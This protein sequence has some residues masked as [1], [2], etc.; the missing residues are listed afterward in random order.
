MAAL[1]ATAKDY[2]DQLSVTVNGSPLGQPEESTIKVNRND[3]G[4]YQLSLEDF[5]LMFGALKVGTIVVDNVAAV[6]KNGA[7]VLASSQSINIEEGSFGSDAKGP[8]LGIVPVNVK[9]EIRDDKLFSLIDINMPSPLNMFI[10]V[11]F[12][13]ST[14]YQIPNSGFEEFHTATYVDG[15][16]SYSS[17][18]PNAWHSFNSGVATG[19]LSM[20]TKLAL[21]NGS[22]YISTD[23]RPESTGTKSVTLVSGNVMKV[24][25]NGTMTTGR[26]QAGSIT[27][28]DPANCAFMDM[29]LTDVDGNGDPFYTVLNGMPDSLTVWVKY[30]Q[31]QENADYPYATVSAVITDGTYYQDPE[32][33]DVTYNNVV[34][35]AQDKEIESKD[36]TWQ[37]VSIPFDYATYAS[38]NA[39]GKALLVTISTNAQ[40]GVGSRDANNPDVLYVDDIALVYNYKLASLSV[41]GSEISGFDED[42]LEYTVD[43]VIT[44]DDIEAVANGKGASVFVTD[45]TEFTVT[46]VA[47]D[48]LNS[49]T[50]TIHAPE[51]TIAKTIPATGLASFSAK[52]NVTVPEGVTVCTAKINDDET[53]VLLN[54]V[55]ANVIPANTG[56]LIWH[57]DGGDFTFSAT[58]TSADESLFAENDLIPTSID[59]KA[60]VPASGVFYALNNAVLEF[61]VLQNGI[62]LGGHLAYLAAPVDATTG[63]AKALRVVFDELTGITEVSATETEG[64]G[65]YYTLQGIKVEKPG[66]GLYIHNGKKVIIK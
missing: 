55:E 66:K 56:V 22:T 38:N 29:S 16:N 65:A 27:A 64:D 34:A 40:P 10:N 54:T 25:A 1:T 53:K 31:G 11:Q 35:K 5:S 43:Q 60:T 63:E 32:D 37:R 39:E 36:F 2:T 19:K 4:T 18:E 7:T 9:A 17:D 26:M 59:A 44:A 13:E 46:V 28:T 45:V 3:D 62:T 24:P 6:E 8:G 23:V 48:L 42:V 14:G 49:T 50:Y 52:T 47:N 15:D 57:K 21:R 12:G 30:K 41:K 20:L 61:G 51:A 58:E 33:P